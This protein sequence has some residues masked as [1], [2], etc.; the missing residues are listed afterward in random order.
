MHIRTNPR[1]NKIFKPMIAFCEWLG[2]H[3]PVLLAR[4]RYFARFKKPLHLKNP[5]T[6]NE[7]ILFLS[8]KT[9]TTLWT[10]CA[11]K[12]EV[13]DYVKEC[14]LEDILIPLVGVW[15]HATDID[16]DKLP[17][18]FVLKATHGSGDIKVVTDKSK[19]NIPKIVAEFEEDLKHQY[20]ALESGHHYMRI[21]PRMIAEELIHNDPET[22]KISS[23]IIDYKIW[24]F[25]GKCYWLW[26]CANRD[27][28]TTEVMTYDTDWNAH[29]EYS[30]FENDY[31]HGDI[32][33]K[34]KN[35]ER[36]IEVAEKL[37]QPFPC[38]RVDLYNIDGKIYFGE[39]TFTSYGGLQDFYTD[40]F[41]QLA[42]SKIDLSGVKVVR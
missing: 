31:R 15:D 21:K 10:R 24:C 4:I 30:I 8:L 5:Q 16:F 1:L 33:P 28:H 18:E 38:V 12:Y 20:G 25:N 11:D 37:A 40:E 2:V 7:K 17:D 19:L 29:P 41:Q 34:P 13:R 14:G 23:S 3:H 36:M 26:A 9:D 42:G 35:L 6:L 32:L 39:L 27:E 22:A